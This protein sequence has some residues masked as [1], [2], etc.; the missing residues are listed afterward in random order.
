M[1]TAQS[2]Q[3]CHGQREWIKTHSAAVSSNVNKETKVV[4]TDRE[5]ELKGRV[6]PEGRHSLVAWTMKDGACKEKDGSEQDDG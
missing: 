4:L 6:A 1:K 5:I 3:S 2:K